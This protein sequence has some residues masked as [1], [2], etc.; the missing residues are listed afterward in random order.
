MKKNFH[1]R[2]LLGA[3]LLF[4]LPLATIACSDDTNDSIETAAANVGSDAV[5]AAGNAG[6]A[7]SSAASDAGNAI[8]SAVSNDSRPEG[9]A[10]TLAMALATSLT[11]M[12]GGGEATITN[13]Q[14]AAKLV[15]SPAKVTGIE[16]SDGNGIDDDAKATIET[17][18]GDDKACV[19]SQEGVWEVTDD[20]C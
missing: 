13:L 5:A 10:K 18:N 2:R 12:P 15:P 4:I 3:S 19:Q 8:D 9:Q 17:E 11:A 1:T 14:E 16:D 6:E 7:L 20:E